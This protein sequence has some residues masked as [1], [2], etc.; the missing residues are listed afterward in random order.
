MAWAHPS[1][2]I[3][4]VC[5]NQVLDPERVGGW[6]A[7]CDSHSVCAVPRAPPRGLASRRAAGSACCWSQGGLQDACGAVCEPG[8]PPLQPQACVSK[9]LLPSCLQLCYIVSGSASMCSP[10]VLLDLPVGICLAFA[11]LWAAVW[12]SSGIYFLLW[13]AHWSS[14]SGIEVLTPA[15]WLCVTAWLLT[16]LSW[17]FFV[18]WAPQEA[19]LLNCAQ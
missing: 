9:Q 8:P 2:S 5:P 12:Y 16:A 15:M 19:P 3:S 17:C 18:L 13:S 4:V 10:S 7:S 14:F 6:C 1:A 11:Q